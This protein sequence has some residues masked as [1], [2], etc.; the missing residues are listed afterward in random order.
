MVE[1]DNAIVIRHGIVACGNTPAAPRPCFFK[2]SVALG[3]CK[4]RDVN[5]S[6][7]GAFKCDSAHARKDYLIRMQKKQH[8]LAEQ[9]LREFRLSMGVT[10]APAAG[11]EDE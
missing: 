4:Y 5:V 10:L 3:R 6:V 11:A 1:L 7:K 9:E 8:V 2:V